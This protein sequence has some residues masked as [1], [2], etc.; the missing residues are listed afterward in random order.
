MKDL[1]YQIELE[2]R[3]NLYSSYENTNILE[4]KLLL[5][6]TQI[7]D[8]NVTDIIDSLI[9][10]NQSIKS[11]LHYSGPIFER[12]IF[13]EA[14]SIKI[15]SCRRAMGKINWFITSSVEDLLY[16]HGRWNYNINSHN[17]STLPQQING[18]RGSGFI[19]NTFSNNS[20]RNMLQA[21]QQMYL[22]N[23]NAFVEQSFGLPD[24]IKHI[25]KCWTPPELLVLNGIA[26]PEVIRALNAGDTTSAIRM[27]NCNVSNEQDIVTSTLLFLEE[28]LTKYT[29][30]VDEKKV[31]IEEQ[32]AILVVTNNREELNEI[33]NKIKNLNISLK[34][35]T[36]KKN[37]ILFKIKSL[38]ERISNI[39]EKTCPICLCEVTSPCLTDCCK[40][41]YCMGCYIK[42]LQYSRNK[43]PHCR[44]PNRQISNVTLIDNTINIKKEE[45]NSL[46]KKEDELIRLIKSKP[47]G[48]FLVFSEY[49]NT[50]N[51]VVN[52][53]KDNSIL[54][55]KLSGSSGRVTNIIKDFTSNKVNVLL[56]NAKNYGSGLN[57]QMTTDIIIY[58]KMSSDLENQ[59]IGRG[60]RLGRTEALN[61]HYLYYENEN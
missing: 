14:N 25:I 45:T 19:K 47:S 32:E 35:F 12:V 13:D 22:K 34:N 50:F 15:P 16:P 52:K 59:V 41:I 21:I 53:L 31:L 23:S 37:D 42:A 56:L 1:V 51:N 3:K 36:T 40:N 58:H 38:K 44:A 26:T 39:R 11:V 27:T 43:C 5:L 49:N 60:Q 29:I 17:Q 9:G 54:Y 7:N 6:K 48:R 2:L 8:L 55:N 24:P 57:L 33:N 30:L 28:S 4:E 20:N 61:V 18:I 46:P 10:K